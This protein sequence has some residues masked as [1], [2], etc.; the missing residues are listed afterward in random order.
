[1][2]EK[3]HDKRISINMQLEISTLFKQDNIKV[4][5]LDMPIEVVN[6]SRT[7]IA[8]KSASVLPLN[9]YFNS[10][11]QLE[12]EKTRF[13]CVVRIVRTEKINESKFLY[14]CKFIGFAPV[15]TKELDEE[16]DYTD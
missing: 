9:Y 14:G 4:E 3:R 7:G 15:F 11:I 1:M 13:Y 10:K 2:Q 5:N 6:V 8:F 16:D 12:D